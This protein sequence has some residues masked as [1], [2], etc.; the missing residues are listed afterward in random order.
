TV[1]ACADAGG[2]AQGIQA[3]VTD[4]TQ[5]AALA[6]AAQAVHGAVD[7]LVNVAGG[8][9]GQVGRPVDE[10]SLADWEEI[11]AV[12]LTGAFLCARAVAPGMKRQRS[13]RIVN[14]SSGAGRSTSLTGIQAYASS[15]AG[16]IG[17][18]RQLAKELGP[19][20]ITCNS[21]APGFL[22][23]NPASRRQWESYGEAGQRALVEGL[24]LRR[25]G[26]PEDIAGAVL[27]FASDLAGWC[28]GQILSVDGGH[29]MF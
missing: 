23:S 9:R 22:L 20:N 8:V 26:A 10:V 6:A 5:V 29:S 3:D 11:L 15:K 2:T 21:V 19:W 12:N 16:Q 25:L 27:F 14:I 13:G 18:T 4:E 7:I 28:T 1:T 17:L 24:A